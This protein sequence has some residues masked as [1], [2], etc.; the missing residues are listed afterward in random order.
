MATLS[1]KQ[2]TCLVIQAGFTGAQV[3]QMVVIAKLESGFRTDARNPIA[4]CTGTQCG[5]ATGLFQI[6]DFPDRVAKYGNLTDPAVNARAAYDIYR[7]QGLGAWSTWTSGVAATVAAGMQTGAV[8]GINLTGLPTT[9][10]DCGGAPQQSQTTDIINPL[11]LSQTIQTAESSF[12]RA[13][14]GYAT[15]G[16]GLTL[17]GLSL[18]AMV[19]VLAPGAIDSKVKELPGILKTVLMVAA[20]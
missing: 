12:T 17:F 5:H 13:L 18:L 16:V 15:G 20:K 11:G 8:L 3:I 6:V 7:S 4:V 1:A 14:V 9:M 2:V 19:I 10:A